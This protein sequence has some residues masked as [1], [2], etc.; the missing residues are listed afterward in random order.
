MGEKFCSHLE[1]WDMAF[2]TKCLLSKS[3]YVS[4]YQVCVCAY[5]IQ[6]KRLQ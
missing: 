4:A 2:T 1:L 5:E 6:R 3:D